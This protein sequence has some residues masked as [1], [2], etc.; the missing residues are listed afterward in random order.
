M[1]EPIYAADDRRVSRLPFTMPRRLALAIFVVLYLAVMCPLGFVLYVGVRADARAERSQDAAC[2]L[3]SISDSVERENRDLVSVADR[4]QRLVTSIVNSLTAEDRA[5][6]RQ[7]IADAVAAVDEILAAAEQSTKT[8]T[9][10]LQ[11]AERFD[12]PCG[13]GTE[14]TSG[15]D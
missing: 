4:Q 11:I 7:E 15:G 9:K 1:S 10:V 13:N 2:T 6:A 8:K 14:N 5:A 12:L 3:I